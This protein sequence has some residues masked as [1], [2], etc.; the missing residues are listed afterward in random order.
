MGLIAGVGINRERWCAWKL[1]LAWLASVYPATASD[2]G[3]VRTMPM[4]PPA[5]VISGTR[6]ERLMRSVP[7]P[8]VGH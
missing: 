1:A 5:A 8:G 6:M 4:P 3:D 2:G 7:S